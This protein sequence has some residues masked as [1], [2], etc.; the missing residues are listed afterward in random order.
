MG[1][2]PHAKSPKRAIHTYRKSLHEKSKN[3]K[4]SRKIGKQT[5]EEMQ[6][7]TVREISEATLKRPS[8]F[9]EHFDRWLTNVEAV[10]SEFKAHPA[11]GV[12]DQFGWECTQTLATV[13]L[14]LDER[15]RKEAT[16]DRETMNLQAWRSRL[17]QINTENAET[18]SELKTRKKMQL[19]RLFKAIDSLKKEQESIVRLKTG[20]FRGLS[21]KAKE[22]KEIEIAQKLNDKQRELELV[23]L[24]F[25]VAQKKLQEDSER[26]REPI[27]EQIKFFR[28]KAA[29]LENDGS[30]EERWFACETLIDAVNS[31][32]QRKAQR[33]PI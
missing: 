5:Q 9:S 30:L 6:T 29:D 11:I 22:Q 19:K 31:F 10:L 13:K 17:K 8:P 14:Q 16:L 33:P 2:R 1:Y 18:M 32:L 26:K 28:K 27:L 4:H 23:F 12:D 3:T 7:V 15:R 21:K 20:F 24:E 25:N